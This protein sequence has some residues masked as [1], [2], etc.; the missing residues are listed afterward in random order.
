MIQKKFVL[1]KDLKFSIEKLR[2]IVQNYNEKELKKDLNQ[3]LPENYRD[4]YK[5][6]KK[7]ILKF[8]G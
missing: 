6:L 7:E 4:F 3:F 8:I 5:S 1:Y 2:K